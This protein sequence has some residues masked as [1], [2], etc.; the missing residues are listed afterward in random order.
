MIRII[1]VDDMMIPGINNPEGLSVTAS[2]SGLKRENK[3]HSLDME[4]VLKF[5]GFFFLN[6]SSTL[7]LALMSLTILMAYIVILKVRINV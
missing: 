6:I 2:F 1:N 3:N 7:I 5:L 4:N